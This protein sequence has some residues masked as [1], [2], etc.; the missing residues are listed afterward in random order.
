MGQGSTLRQTRIELF[1]TDSY[2]SIFLPEK[3]AT[4]GFRVGPQ[5]ISAKAYS[6]T[7]IIISSILITVL[8][9]K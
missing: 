2:G 4:L 5:S 1:N 7:L 6:V 8:E 9:G 3:N